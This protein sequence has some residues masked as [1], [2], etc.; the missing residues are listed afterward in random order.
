MLAIRRNRIL[1]EPL[2]ATTTEA[3]QMYEELGGSLSRDSSF[4]WDPLV[5]NEEAYQNRVDRFLLL[6]PT[7]RSIFSDVV[8]G[9][10]DR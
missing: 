5:M 4:D 10:K 7:G 6:E 3:V 1:S 2:I 9:K 8:S